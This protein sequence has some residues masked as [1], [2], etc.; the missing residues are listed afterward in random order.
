M[1]FGCGIIRENMALALMYIGSMPLRLFEYFK[2][3]TC[4]FLN[5]A[6]VAALPV[7]ACGI[8]Q[9]WRH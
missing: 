3:I 2:D 5:Q 9:I 6:D 7:M 8:A 4:H 1:W